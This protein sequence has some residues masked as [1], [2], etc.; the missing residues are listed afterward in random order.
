[1]QGL[2]SSETASLFQFIIPLVGMICL[3]ISL[4]LYSR[5]KKLSTG[6]EKMQEIANAIRTGSFAYLKRQNK[7][8]IVFGLV[9]FLVFISFGFFFNDY[10]WYGIALSFVVGAFSSGL[11]GYIG[12]VVTSMANVRTAEAARKGLQSALEV[13]FKAGTIMGFALIGLGLIGI[14]LLMSILPFIV[15]SS[16][17]LSPVLQMLAGMGFGASLIAMFARVGGGIYTK[18]AD[19][20]AD[21]VGK[22]EAGIPEDDPR[23][24]AVIADNVGDNVGDCAGMGADL[25]ESYIVTLIGAMILGYI[26]YG[27]E[28]VYFPLSVAAA[29]ALASIFGMQFVKVKNDDDN[30]LSALNR[31]ILVS[32]LVSALL[33]IVIA[34][35][36]FN[37]AVRTGIVLSSLVG[38][39]VAL[40]IMYLTDYYTSNH[41]K[42]VREIADS[43]KTGAGTNIITGM[44]VGLENSAMFIVIIVVGIMLAYYFGG[45]YGVAIAAMSMLALTGIVISVD[46]FGPVSDNAGGIVEMS[47]LEESIRKITDK[48]DAV[49]NTTKATT[50]GFAIASAGLAALALMLAFT[51]EVNTAAEK[52]GIPGFDVDPQTKLP[53]INIMEPSVL[54]G[55][56]I[57]AG[58]TFLFSAISLKSVGFAAMSIVEEVRRQFRE[59]PGIMKGEEKPDYARCV[60]ICTKSAIDQLI[61]LGI[62]AVFSPLIVGFLF[63][64]K[65]VLGLLVGSLVAG[66]ALAVLMTTGGAAW[67]NAKKY[68]EQ[69]GEKGTQQ[70]KAAVVGDTVGDAFKDTTGP[71]LNP[72]IKI[73]NTLSLLFVVLFLKF[74]LKII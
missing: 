13:S 60:D 7:T 28:G 14:S 24:P 42:P 15:P 33:F 12:M 49:G 4:Y 37:D 57:G 30:P 18:G 43:A 72:L 20:G 45:I 39:V 26:V 31:S 22:V 5:L 36:F 10:I 46:T 68:I 66:Q 8:V 25:F 16:D 3:G 35:F 65:G 54:L 11:A 19:V 9:I 1:M 34:Q 52:L 40:A 51:N 56:F 64:V 73:L 48:L 27:L 70:H 50:K 58:V 62:V 55:I 69:R 47:G 67:D 29:A 61:P 59:K 44:A 17:S 41:Y 71:S 74:A 2:T 23:N 6:N 32:A 53:V 38:L 63:G 21:L